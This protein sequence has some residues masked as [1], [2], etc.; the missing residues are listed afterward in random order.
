MLQLKYGVMMARSK[1]VAVKEM[2]SDQMTTF[3]GSE[4]SIKALKY[5]KVSFTTSMLAYY[6]FI[7][8]SI[9]FPTA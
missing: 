5:L 1:M 9:H 2:A 7:N 8:Y 6:K 4:R 3:K